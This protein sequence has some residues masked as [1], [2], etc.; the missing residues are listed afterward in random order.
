MTP[1]VS[2]LDL[3]D[4]TPSSLAKAPA[5]EL[6]L[7]WLRLHQWFAEAK[8]AGR[9]V[10][11]FVN[12]GTFVSREMDRRKLRYSL[13]SA[14]GEEIE[15]LRRSKGASLIEAVADRV[16][17]CGD[18]VLI[19]DFVSVVGSCARGVPEPGDMDVVV[20]AD[21]DAEQRHALLSWE[22]TYLP[23]RNVLNPGKQH[24]LDMIFNAQ[25]PHGDY[26]PIYDLVLRKR[27]DPS[28]VVVKDAGPPNVGTPG[29]PYIDVDLGCGAEPEEGWL[30]ID[31]VPF[32]KVDVVHDLNVGIPLPDGCCANVRACHSLEH[33]AD[34]DAIMAEVWRVLA[35]GGLFWFEIP[36]TTGE[37]AFNHPGHRTFWNATSFAFWTNPDLREDRPP[38]EEVFLSERRAGPS[39]YVEGVLRKPK[40]CGPA[41]A[42]KIA[43]F[44]PFVPPKPLL[45]G[46]T[47]M[48]STDELW[49]WAEKRL[50]IDVEP[51]WNGFR[52]IAERKGA[53]VRLW[54]EGRRGRDLLEHFPAYVRE[55][56]LKLIG[57]F[58]LD[59]DVGIER[60]GRRLARPNL[61][62]LNSAEPKLGEGDKIVVTAFDLP[63]HDADLSGKSF[64][65]RRRHLELLAKDFAGPLALS[66]KRVVR[67]RTEMD[68]AVRWG[69]AFPMSEGVVA[70]T[71]SGNYEQGGTDEWSK[72][73]RIV[74]LKVTVIDVK[75]VTGGARSYRG[76][77]LPGRDAWSNVREVGGVP[78]VDLGW[79]F[80]SAIKA[81]VGDVVTARVLEL[82]IDGDAKTLTWLGATIE[83]IDDSRT[84]PYT[85]AQ[86]IDVARRGEVLQR[87][88]T[89]KIALDAGAAAVAALF[90]KAEPETRGEAAL[91]NWAAR[92][93]KLLPSGG[94]G[95]FVYHHHWRGLSEDEAKLGEGALLGTDHSIHGDLRMEGDDSLWG[96]SVFL[97]AAADVRRAG[98]DRLESLPKGDALQGAFKEPQPKEWLNVAGK[99]PLVVAPEGVGATSRKWAKFFAV[100]HGTYEVGLAKEH[101]VELFMDGPR[102]KGRYLIEAVPRGGAERTWQIVKP[103]DQRPFAETTT[104]DEQVADQKAKG[105]KWV[106][107]NTPGGSPKI[108]DVRKAEDVG[109]DGEP[110]ESAVEKK[111]LECKIGKADATEYVVTGVV[112][113]PLLAEDGKTLIGEPDT[114]GDVYTAEDIRAAMFDFMTNGRQTIR[115]RHERDI[116][117]ARVVECF[118]APVDMR[119]PK[120]DGSAEVVRAGSWVLSVCLRDCPATWAKVKAGDLNAFSIG[121]FGPR[122]ELRT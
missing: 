80:N 10:E 75:D 68:D 15:A 91:A 87:S 24:K 69:Y 5:S 35:P 34:K 33:L 112:L 64:E 51:K 122:E 82:D 25:G 66:P 11:P 47:E 120:P 78:Y 104:L 101:L 44:D 59:C 90:A 1:R 73:K 49:Q 39:T 63:Y 119:W 56:L 8:K 43:P 4:M 107:W 30:G 71:L 74:E 21:L 103:E 95:R 60:D 28:R 55:A 36:S 99:Q 113:E 9:A 93:P 52:C 117:S 6:R 108:V 16:A 53:R 29:C 14:L 17:W 109:A 48:F 19:P 50:P 77:L 94:G 67:S 115:F 84:K 7:A 38:F 86:S 3:I 98:G 100:D 106:Y 54:S 85:A 2:K 97:G 46:Y 62:T 121:G 58:V 23:V 118:Q 88:E 13:D 70:K 26:V 18:V 65:E 76:G 72:L 41:H 81:K 61:Q 12:A 22:S 110:S 27:S 116:E 105:R 37:G 42:A 20:R 57:D 114:Q 40:D 79:S 83:D 92:W 31:V 96:F 102:L 111:P 45:A 89:V 32:P